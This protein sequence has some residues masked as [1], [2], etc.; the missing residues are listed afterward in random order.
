MP[1][2]TVTDTLPLTRPH[3]LRVPPLPGPNTFKPSLSYSGLKSYLEGWLIL[4]VN[5]AYLEKGTSVET[6]LWARLWYIF[7][8]RD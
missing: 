6:G 7:P 1:S 4:V 2:P 3:F 5:L 8:D